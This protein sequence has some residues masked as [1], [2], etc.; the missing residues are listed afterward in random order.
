MSCEWNIHCV[1][2]DADAG[3]PVNH[4]DGLMRGLID[5]RGAI[6]RLADLLTSTS[7]SL[8]LTV[9]GVDVP[10]RFFAAHAGHR[11]EPLNEYGEFDGRCDQS[12]EC[13][14]CGPGVC[15]RARHPRAE[16]RNLSR[17]TKHRHVGE[18]HEIHWEG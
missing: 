10:V 18:D 8:G 17:S 9:D 2:C 7:W 6:E 4:G 3:M 16:G 14:C 13:V 15:D 11:L 12:F 5:R 1:D